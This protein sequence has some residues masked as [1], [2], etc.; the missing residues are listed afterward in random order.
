MKTPYN[1]PKRCIANLKKGDT[2]IF[3]GF[4]KIPYVFSHSN[5]NYIFAGVNRPLSRFVRILKIIKNK[6]TTND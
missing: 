3:A 5:E 2:I 4:E 1:A 6:L